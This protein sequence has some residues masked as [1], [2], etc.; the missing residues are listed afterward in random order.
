MYSTWLK[1][2][3]LDESLESVAVPVGAIGENDD[4]EFLLR[5]TCHQ[6]FE[7]T[8]VAR[9]VD[10]AFVR[11]DEPSVTVISAGTVLIIAPTASADRGVRAHGTA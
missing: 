6:C 3:L 9:V 5:V 7:T 4:E 10:A 11:F 1:E 2:E 8:V